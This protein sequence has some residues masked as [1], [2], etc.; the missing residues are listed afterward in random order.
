MLPPSRSPRP[1]PVTR[2]T[3]PERGHPHVRSGFP[4]YE[5]D[6]RSRRSLVVRSGRSRPW[7]VRSR[8]PG[9]GGNSSRALSGAADVQRLAV[10]LVARLRVQV[11]VVLGYV[12]G[13]EVGAGGDRAVHGDTRRVDSEGA[14]LLIE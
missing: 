5:A 8:Q 11:P 9:A 4:C 1:L 14:V 10:P 12:V 13:V 2:R 7:A 6:L 3:Q